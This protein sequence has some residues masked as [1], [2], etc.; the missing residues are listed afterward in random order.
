M[1]VEV[2]ALGSPDLKKVFLQRACLC[3]KCLL[4]HGNESYSINVHQICCKHFN[5]FR[6]DGRK[7]PLKMLE[8]QSLSKG[9]VTSNVFADVSFSK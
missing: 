1:L 2:Y 7:G 4:Q 3:A 5:L 6:I 8:S 9:L